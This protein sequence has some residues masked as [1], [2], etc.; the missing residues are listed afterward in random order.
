MR[1]QVSELTAPL[2]RLTLCA[3]K[4]SK[5]I[6]KGR[7]AHV[8]HAGEE[9]KPDAQQSAA[10]A[11]AGTSNPGSQGAV[12]IAREMALGDVLDFGLEHGHGGVC[13]GED[14]A[15]APV[16]AAASKQAQEVAAG[17]TIAAAAVGEEGIGMELSNLLAAESVGQMGTGASRRQDTQA[18]VS[19]AGMRHRK[20]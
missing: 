20:P 14:V 8:D 13:V 4:E 3:E 9:G 17:G 6:R 1:G 11:A 19:P 2:R 15:G 16:A 10:T 7:C 5:G 12:E 18:L